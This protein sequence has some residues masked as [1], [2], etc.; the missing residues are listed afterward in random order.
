MFRVNCGADQQAGADGVAEDRSLPHFP[1]L[2]VTSVCPREGFE[3]CVCVCVCVCGGV[4]YDTLTG[5]SYISCL[6]C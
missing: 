3:L 1:Y 6:P 5:W 4:A 2:I